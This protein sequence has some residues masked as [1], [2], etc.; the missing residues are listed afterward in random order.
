MGF[1]MNY[2]RKV[3]REAIQYDFLYFLDEDQD[4][5]NEITELGGRIYK[6]KKPSIGLDSI[7]E[8]DQ[9]FSRIGKDY[10]IV[11]NHEVYLSF[12]F[13]PLSKKHGNPSFIS[14]SHTTK[15]SPKLLNRFRNTMLCLPINKVSDY[16]FACSREAGLSLF[17]KKWDT[18]HSY[19]IPNAID[20]NKFSFS[21]V[22]R[23]NARKKLGVEDKFVIGNVGRLE[24]GKNQSRLV[25][26]FKEIL[27]NRKNSVLILVGEGP[28]QQL[29]D[30]KVKQLGI[31][32]AVMFL[33]KR[34]DIAD[35]YC[36]MD[37]FVFTSLY[38]GLGIVLIEAQCSGL[39]CISSTGVPKMTCVNG[40]YFEFVDLKCSNEIW[41]KKALQFN[42]RADNA[43]VAVKNSGF[44]ISVAVRDMEKLYYGIAEK[45]D[46]NELDNNIS[47]V[48]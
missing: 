9:L 17:R 30:T 44:D 42:G 25:D 46:T 41:A 13:E 38:E 11:H 37:L 1:L 39:P 15:L 7:K 10:P 31:E 5:Y 8:I 26:I 16:R 22:K 2:Y 34:A 35:L 20:C 6:I 47:F 3:D 48:R 33:G 43:E 19:I 24:P 29:I 40:N 45:R 12:I 4:I 18:S 27:K 14:H 23:E 21:E 28:D 36:A 32:N